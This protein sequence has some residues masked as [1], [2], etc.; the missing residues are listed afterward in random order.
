MLKLSH[1]TSINPFLHAQANKELFLLSTSARNK[2]FLS[3]YNK[4][5]YMAHKQQISLLKI[6]IFQ[7]PL[8]EHRYQLVFNFRKVN[9]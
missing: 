4:T 2:Y 8:N 9:Y 3:A 7:I 1:I 5:D 6:T